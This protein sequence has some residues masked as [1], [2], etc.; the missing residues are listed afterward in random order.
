MHVRSGSSTHTIIPAEFKPWAEPLGYEIRNGDYTHDEVLR[1]LHPKDGATYYRLPNLAAEYQSL[2]IEAECL[3][4]ESNIDWY[5]NG[6]FLQTTHKPHG[7][8]WQ[9]RPG[10]FK[11]T[12]TING[13]T[14][15][16]K[17]VHFIV[18]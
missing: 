18:K 10:T 7:F 9:I 6:K 4:Q 14:N 17:E 15:Q 8:L 13:V 11:L 2:R 12:A 16:S 5:L 3:E 1:I